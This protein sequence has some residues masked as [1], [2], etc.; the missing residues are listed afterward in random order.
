MN[1]SYRNINPEVRKI[2][3]QA[4]NKEPAFDGTVL[5][6]RERRY[7]VINERDFLKY[8]PEPV[9]DEF[10]NIFTYAAD[11]IEAGR[12]EVGKKP[13]NNYIVI[14][15]DEPYIDEI[16]AVMKKHGHWDK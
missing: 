16:I 2:L 8:V 3:L 12:E 15:T 6:G 11:Y 5:E 13:Y 1:T 7:T 10:R 14:N 4:K 9:K